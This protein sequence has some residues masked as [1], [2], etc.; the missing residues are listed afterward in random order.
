MNRTVLINNAGILAGGW[1]SATKTTVATLED[2]FRANVVGPIIVTLA[3][4]PLL[5]KGTAKQV[6]TVGSTVGS[7]GGPFSLTAN[8]TSYAVSKAAVHMYMKK[9]CKC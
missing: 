3:L 4:L 9:L 8:A 1:D 2:N 6:F 7:I 5:K